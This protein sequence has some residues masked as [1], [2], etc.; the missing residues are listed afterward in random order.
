MNVQII[1]DRPIWSE[2]GKLQNAVTLFHEIN[3]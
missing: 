3:V 1:K 2:E